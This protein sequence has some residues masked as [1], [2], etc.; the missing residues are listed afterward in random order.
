MQGSWA[1]HNDAQ[2]AC[3][4]LHDAFKTSAMQ[5]RQLYFVMCGSEIQL[6][7]RVQ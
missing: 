2:V 6:T 3:E 7:V 5:D 4:M 1:K